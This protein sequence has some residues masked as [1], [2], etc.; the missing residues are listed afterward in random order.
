MNFT[1]IHNIEDSIA[2]AVQN[3]PYSH[4]G[5]I[6]VTGLVRPPQMAALEYQHRNEIE[7]DVSDKLWALLGSAVHVILDRAARTH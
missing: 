7:E 5:D 4:S 3:D 2:R 1:N 6:S